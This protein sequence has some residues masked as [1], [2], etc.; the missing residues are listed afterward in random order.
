MIR[1]NCYDFK[2]DISFLLIEDYMEEFAEA[3]RG[4]SA[5]LII[6]IPRQNTLL[7]KP[8]PKRKSMEDF[9]KVTNGDYKRDVESKEKYNERVTKELLF[10]DIEA[11]KFEIYDESIH[12][13]SK[14]AKAGTASKSKKTSGYEDFDDDEQYYDSDYD[15]DEEYYSQTNDYRQSGTR[16]ANTPGYTARPQ[17]Y[18]Q[19]YG[20]GYGPPGR[21]QT[22][23]RYDPYSNYR[24]AASPY[25]GVKI[26]AVIAI[27]V[28]LTII[29]A[30]CSNASSR[31]ATTAPR[32]PTTQGPVGAPATTG[33]QGT[34]GNSGAAG[35]PGA[36]AAP[37]EPSINAQTVLEGTRWTGSYTPRASS[38][39]SAWNRDATQ[40]RLTIEI[41]EARAD[42]TIKATVTASSPEI[43]QTSSG[44][45]DANTLWISLTFDSWIIQPGRPNDN[46]SDDRYA[47]FLSAMQI[48]LS[49]N[50]DID[51]N[52]MSGRE[53]GMNQGGFDA[54]NVSR[55][56]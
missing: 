15:D 34:G 29:I 49:G 39:V 4:E 56:N 10:Y 47:T 48:N 19:A 9:Q 31:R 16:H 3:S 17:A 22:N 55:S 42:G 25:R 32:A 1:I 6:A 53:S 41:T 38:S 44:T 43:S 8:Q 24:Y 27:L 7:F 5:A 46:M 51:N 11:K 54:F 35:A 20:H 28:I 13:P 37:D 18:G 14:R 45:F 52:T 26:F 2:F 50:I 21:G 30:M 33:S 23:G 12:K 36:A 40:N